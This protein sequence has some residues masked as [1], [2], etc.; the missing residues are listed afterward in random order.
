MTK[1][2]ESRV[3][4]IGGSPVV[5][6]AVLNFCRRRGAAPVMMATELSQALRSICEHRVGFAVVMS[7]TMDGL[8]VDPAI[9]LLE[10]RR[11]P[12]LW[13]D[14]GSETPNCIR[15]LE[16]SFPGKALSPKDVEE[17]LRSALSGARAVHMNSS[18]PVI[19][20]SNGQ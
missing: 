12:F 4:I 17:A 9:T 18:P 16:R 2:S 1:G 3:L 10:A 8:T 6:L 14:C 15:M 5:R 20:W 13:I 19:T 7:E 11:I